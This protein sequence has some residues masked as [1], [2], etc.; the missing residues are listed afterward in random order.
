[1][2]KQVTRQFVLRAT[3]PAGADPLLQPAE[4]QEVGSTIRLLNR[5]LRLN[6]ALP[7]RGT[8]RGQ[9]IHADTREPVTAGTVQAASTL[10]QEQR[11]VELATD[12]TFTVPGL[13]VGPITLTVR[14]PEGRVGYATVGIDEPGAVVEALVEVPRL[15]VGK[16]TVAG[17]VVTA[18]VDEETGERR[19][20][21]GATVSVYSPGALPAT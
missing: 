6:I 11:K 16:G 17:V 7:G 2:D 14:D 9:A 3:I 1:W 19:P 20:I 4:V 12:G 8:V 18:S 15:V 5:M 10:F 21:G 13:P